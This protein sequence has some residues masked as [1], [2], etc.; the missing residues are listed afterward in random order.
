MFRHPFL[1]NVF[2]L[3]LLV[4]IALPSYSLLVDYPSFN[5]LL[6]QVTEDHAL[7]MG[8]HLQTYLTEGR[9][10]ENLDLAAPAFRNKVNTLL[11]DA[12]LLKLRVFNSKGRI[13]FST[14]PQETGELNDKD[15]F[16]RQVAS[17][18][19]FSKVGKKG[20]E[21]M[22]GDA[23]QLDVVETYVPLMHDGRFIGAFELYTDITENKSRQDHQLLRSTA[24]LIWAALGIL[25][26][27]V[28]VLHRA[29][30][31]FDARERADAEV[32]RIGHQREL[33]LNA[34]GEGVYGI[35]MQGRTT[36]INPAAASMLGW[37]GE[38]L[39]G[40]TQHE[41]VH[42][43]REDGSEFPAGECPIHATCE[44]G[45]P[46]RVE[47]DLFWTRA[48][49][50]VP[51]AYTVTP[52]EEIGARQGAV[53]V[54]RN[55]SERLQA[56][57]NLRD[58]TQKA[59]AASKAK[60][61]FLASMSHEIRTP[62]NGMLGMTELLADTRLDS[63]QREY[64]QVIARSGQAL[65]TIINDILDFSKIEA[66]KLTLERIPFDLERSVYEVVQLFGTRAEEKGIEMVV[67]YAAN[68]PRNLLG[69]PGRLRQ[70]LL[71]LIGNAVKFT[72]SGYVLVRIEGEKPAADD[73]ATLRIAV[74]DTGIGISQ[75]IQA[76]LFQSFT[77]ADSSTTRRF[78]G[79]GLG[80][81]IS[82][83]LVHLMDGRIEVMSQPGEGTE[84]QV[85]LQ[86]P[87]AGPVA[88]LPE[89]GLE[90]IKV[91]VVDDVVVNRQI[92]HQM[93][94]HMQMQPLEA[95]G[96][97]PALSLLRQ[98]RDA[99]EPVQLAIL[100]HHMPETDGEALAAKIHA[101][102]GYADLPLVMLTSAGQRG[103]AEH[104]RQLGFSAYL[105]KPVPRNL[106]Q[107][108]LATALGMHRAHPGHNPIITRHQL[109]ESR[110]PPAPSTA[111]LQG[112][113]LLAEDVAANQLV[114]RSMLKRMGLEVEIAGNGVEAL[115]KWRSGDID[116]I[117][118]DCQM[119]RMD[120]YEASRSIRRE[121]DG[122]SVPIIALTANAYEENRRQCL[123]A[124][125]NDFLAKPFEIC[126]L[127]SVLERWLQRRKGE[128]DDPPPSPV[129]QPSLDKLRRQL[130]EDFQEVVDACL[131]SAWDILAQLPGAAETGDAGTLE[132]LAHSLKSVS[133]NVGATRLSALAGELEQAAATGRLA[134]ASEMISGI[135][136]EEGAVRV[137]LMGEP[138]VVHR[139]QASA[140]PG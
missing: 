132:R 61:A 43:T 62:M 11:Q 25:L 37:P 81:A 88:P 104:F 66:G 76:R 45:R 3:T 21:A 111:T 114:A 135:A 28:V 29:A 138:G 49:T 58:S 46:R 131:Q 78:G 90:G 95:A 102:A 75:E 55:I 110:R 5:R 119:P 35:D 54:F 23:L 40:R 115:E 1:R 31:S 103:D 32:Q 89:A 72:E 14:D 36:F 52:I 57:A 133:A 84:F 65:M 41:L 107:Q 86:L 116:L 2:W 99:G 92:L 22:E 139:D 4:A 16:H 7:R 93:L 125:M 97:E 123:E 42:H 44:D 109:D 6:V 106:L 85:D 8:R 77:Q 136:R 13:L 39:I 33:I 120:G 71:N 126:Q 51:V 130:G 68:C 10:L 124:G 105:V 100:D 118:M 64:V 80:L 96:P 73:R 117:L 17:G 137:A 34:L 56:E 24:L 127:R 48:G 69:D 30:H 101:E 26:V 19:A 87:L 53:V 108:S 20:S 134:Q 12:S 38:E 83:Q 27:M 47:Q 59:K 98:A 18:Q 140:P 91:L 67:D 50:A 112:R 128:A 63:A 129:H 82:Q 70:I 94:Q 60:S 122:Q 113:I 79:T 15:Y 121:S 9:D 74:K